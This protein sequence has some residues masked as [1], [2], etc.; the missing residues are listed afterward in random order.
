MAFTQYFV[1]ISTL[2]T[3]TS[4]KC[5]DFLEIPGGAKGVKSMGVT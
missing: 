1:C 2:D 5:T 3:I 4:F